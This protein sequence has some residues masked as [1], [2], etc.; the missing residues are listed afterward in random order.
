LKNY[1]DTAW[2][3]TE[4]LN[5]LPN[6]PAIGLEYLQQDVA[7]LLG[8][9]HIMVRISRQI[10]LKGSRGFYFCGLPVMLAMDSMCRNTP[11][12]I[13]I[14]FSWVMFRVID[15]L[16]SQTISGCFLEPTLQ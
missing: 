13:E 14:V 16:M 6:E 15:M 3:Y 10:L 8:I 1:V 5:D 4:D 9:G 2:K 7:D 12:G 11:K